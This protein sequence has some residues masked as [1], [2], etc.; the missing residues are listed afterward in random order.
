[1]SE[2]PPDKMTTKEH[3]VRNYLLVSSLFVGIVQA[4][5][6]AD[7]AS[8]SSIALKMAT[9]ILIAGFINSLVLKYLDSLY[10]QGKIKNLKSASMTATI[11]IS[12]ILSFL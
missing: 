12:M 6:G 10:N 1:M 7:A 5:H 2:N 3:F 9:W 8:Y 11:A 4:F